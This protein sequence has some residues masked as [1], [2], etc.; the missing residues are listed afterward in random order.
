VTDRAAVVERLEVAGCVA[1]DE[2]AGELWAAAPDA[3]TLEAWVRRRER[4]EPLAWITGSTWFCGRPLAV[5]AGLYVPR[6]QTEELAVRAAAHLPPAGR[7]A[8]LCTGTGAVA[9][10]LAASVPG[11][12]IVGVDVDPRAAACARRNL[13]PA[14]AADLADPP[15]RLGSFDLVTAVAPYVPTDALALLPADVQRYE[16]RRALDGGAD[17]LDLVRQVVVAAAGLLRPGGWLLLELG[18]DQ[19]AA[20]AP[21]LATV[22]FEPAEPWHDEDGDLRGTAARRH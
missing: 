17:G 9:S 11:A 19:D 3:G 12:A 20:L 22:G 16:P 7:A 18:G 10:H 6:Y 1:A 15:L 2:E 21:T 8:D 5:D 14:V 13:V 4:G